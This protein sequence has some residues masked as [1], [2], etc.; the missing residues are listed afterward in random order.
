MMT[1]NAV[2]FVPDKPELTLVGSKGRRKCEFD[3]VSSRREN[4]NGEWV[5]VW[6]R[7]TFVAW[8][9]DAQRCAEKLEAG[10]DIHAVGLQETSSWTPQG[11]TK[12]VYRTKYRLLHWERVGRRKA[13]ADGGERRHQA[14]SRPA[15]VNAPTAAPGPRREHNQ[16]LPQAYDW[17]GYDTD[18]APPQGDP[19]GDRQ[20]APRASAQDRQFLEM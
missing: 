4:R 3:V 20:E 16:S 12:P 18:A 13:T 17:E 11:A 1:L 19:V 2:G 9:E 7:A 8:E 15:H 10:M 6:E 5:D 14:P